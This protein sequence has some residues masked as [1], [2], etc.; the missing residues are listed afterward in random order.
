MKYAGAALFFI[1]RLNVIMAKSKYLLG[2]D[3]GSSSIKV[4]ILDSESGRAV[5]A[6]S[7]SGRE[8]KINS[9]KKEW[10]E[11]NPEDW[12][13]HTVTATKKALQLSGVDPKEIAAIGIAYQMHGLV[14]VD[15]KKKV[16]RP[17][18]I[19]CDSRA[20]QIGNRAFQEIGEEMCLN[21]YLNSPGNFTA[22]K[23][24]WVRENEPEVFKKIHK[25]M[26]PGDFISMKLTGVINTTFSGLS[27]GILWNYKTSS[28][29]KDLLNYFD[30][31]EEYIPDYSESFS[32]H[33]TV[34]KTAAE[35][36]G[37]KKGTP[38]T[39]KAGDQPNNA[40]S[41]NVMKPGEIATTAGTSGV[42]FGVTDQPVFEKKSRVNTFIHVNHTSMAERYGVLLCINGTGILNRWLRENITGHSPITYEEMNHRSAKIEPGANGLTIFPFGNGSERL[43]EN[44]QPG[45]MI[46]DLHFNLHTSDH[47]FR[48]AQEGIVFSMMMGL[49]VMNGLGIH[50][51]IIKAGHSNMFLSDVFRDIFVQTTGMSLELYKT[52][53]AQ[54]AARGAG[55]GAGIFSNRDE[56]FESLR[57]VQQANP[58]PNKHEIYT[59]IYHSWKEKLQSELTK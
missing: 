33:G 40:L 48:A 31:S 9:P 45:A 43:L 59:E 41:L 27:E 35:E 54:G 29:A 5:S 38:V 2:I 50:S 34:N 7:P 56:A 22:S 37:L 58:D 14:L 46:R 28:I 6:A 17:S 47:F 32:L 30:L 52:D 15:K 19:W 10:A 11:Q 12:W 39:Y 13:K 49:E 53:G 44:R 36:L 26:L 8:M 3:A 4:S 21:N 55:L 18:I 20:T 57:L 25:T 24:R 1:L 16:I 42:I 51:K 23:L